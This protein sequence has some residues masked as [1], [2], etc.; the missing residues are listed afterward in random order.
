[1]RRGIKLFLFVILVL[2]RTNNTK[3]QNTKLI[4]PILLK[5][6]WKAKWITYPEISGTEYG[7]YLFRKNFTLDTED[8]YFIV[9]VSADNRY[10]LYVN[11]QYVG[12]GPARGDLMKWYFETI[13]LAP[14]LKKGENVIAAEVWNYAEYRPLAQFTYQTRFI[15]QG[16]SSTENVVNS[17]STWMALR[18]TAYSPIKIDINQYYVVGPGEKFICENHPWGWKDTEFKTIGWTHAKEAEPGKPVRSYSYYGEPSPLTLY[19]REIP[20]ME[21]TMQRFGA[22]RR[23]DIPQ[24]PDVFLTGKENLT[25]PKHS[26]VKILFDQGRLTN[27]YPVLR[28]SMGRKSIIKLT[29]AESLFNDKLEKGNRNDIGNKK[30]IGN[31]DMIVSGGMADQIYQTLWWRT[32]GYVEMEVETQ[33]DSLIIHDFYSIFT[34]YPFAEKASFRCNDT[35]LTNIWNA[36]WL[37]QRLCA[38]ETYFDCPYYEQL[39]YVGD[40]R[41]EALVSSSVSGDTRLMRSAI[42]RLYDSRLPFGLTQSRYPATSVQIIPTFSLVW[43]TMVCDYWMICDDRA[44]V[45]SMIPVVMGALNWFESKVDSTQMVGNLEW[46]HFVDW[47]DQ[48]NWNRG[49]PPGVK[50]GHSSI[51]NLQ[52]VY[53]VQKVAALLEAFG[54]EKEAAHYLE[55][56]DHIKTAVYGS[57][58]DSQKGLIADTPDKTSFSQH[59]NLFAVL[60]NTFPKESQRRVMENILSNNEIAQCTLYF[61]YYLAEA[62]EHAELADRYTDML[63]P[64]KRMLDSGLTTFAE[65]PDPTRSDCHAW[66]A[67]PVY[68]FLSLICGIKPNEPG[69]NSIRIEPHLGN[70]NWIKGAMPHQLGIIKV[71][72][73]KDGQNH[74]TGE[75]VLPENLTGLFR[76]HGQSSSLK[77]GLNKIQVKLD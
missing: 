23:S 31:Y 77:S 66:S 30:V 6:Q 60:T 40:T 71:D 54:M 20:A 19:P 37:T 57:C 10:K 73:K 67:S 14:Y 47:I 70:L 27:A 28:F 48:K 59:A 18:D 7:V 76:W 21:T 16:N 56:T 17:D 33:D 24:I 39:Q 55:L 45:R 4:N 43:V 44:F 58:Y 29:Y 72:L 26:K 1:M 38:G 34:G 49:I 41:I 25:I 3:A 63:G 15:I 12:N 75:I 64:W 42:S 22:I 61:R 46:W 11:G 62:V 68:H 35:L 13:D 69:F 2:A 32:F 8:K 5:E 9:H 50:G 53:T 52:F 65:T 74:L 51:I 36:G